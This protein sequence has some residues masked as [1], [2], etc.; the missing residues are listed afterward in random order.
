MSA[1]GDQY[2]FC[3]ACKWV[4]EVKGR[5]TQCHRCAAQPVRSLSVTEVMEALETGD[6]AFCDAC[7]VIHSGDHRPLTIPSYWR[8]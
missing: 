2:Y 8:T 1:H 6:A 5:A 4:Q 3:P 7:S